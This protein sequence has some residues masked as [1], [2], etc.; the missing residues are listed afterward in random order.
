[1]DADSKE[2]VILSDVIR[3]QNLVK[4]ILLPILYNFFKKIQ[5]RGYNF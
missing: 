1:M 5:F 3:K 4:S 2:N